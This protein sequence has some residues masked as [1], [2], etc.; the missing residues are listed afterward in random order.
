M[1]ELNLLGLAHLSLIS[2]FITVYLTSPSPFPS[3]SLINRSE[4]EI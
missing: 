2:S 3:S 4:R 1:I